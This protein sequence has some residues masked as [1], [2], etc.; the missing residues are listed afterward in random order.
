MKVVVCRCEDVLESDLLDAISGGNEDIESLKRYTGFGT[1]VCQGKSCLVHVA[2]I[3]ERTARKHPDDLAPFTPRPPVAPIP[4]R[5]LAAE[6][7]DTVLN[8]CAKPPEGTKR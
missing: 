2:S 4:M 1:G 5:L 7:E 6:D 3:L 8:L